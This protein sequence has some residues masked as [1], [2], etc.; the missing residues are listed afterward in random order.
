MVVSQP[1]HLA[2][3]ELLPLSIAKCQSPE[4]SK[5]KTLPL[6][7]SARPLCKPPVPFANR[8]SPRPLTAR[9]SARGGQNEHR[10]GRKIDG[11]PSAE[12]TEYSSYSQASEIRNLQEL[13]KYRDVVGDPLARVMCLNIQRGLLSLSDGRMDSLVNGAIKHCA[14]ARS[15]SP[16][17]PPSLAQHFDKNGVPSDFAK[18][19][20][21]AR[22]NR[23][24]QGGN[25]M[26]QPSP[27]DF[28]HPLKLQHIR[29][30]YAEARRQLRKDREYTR[31]AALA[32]S[33]SAHLCDMSADVTS[34]PSLPKCPH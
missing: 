4:L 34:I 16:G 25:H 10:F 14:A 11:P 9:P 23:Q 13:D 29:D 6:P 30:G 18:Q 3:P 7:F 26:T 17:F 33:Q 15:A 32:Q 1:A 8:S 2:G 27:R 31:K 21:S 28:V 19:P 20:L 24:S 12:S 5:T 22:W